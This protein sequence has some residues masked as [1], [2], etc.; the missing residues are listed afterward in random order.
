[1]NVKIIRTDDNFLILEYKPR[2]TKIKE[3]LFNN[4]ENL[5][6]K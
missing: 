5:K 3:K 2:V 1:M 6:I 4:N